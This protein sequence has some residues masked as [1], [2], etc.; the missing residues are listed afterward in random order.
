MLVWLL[1][2]CVN[3]CG[4]GTP[5][6]EVSFGSSE[7]VSLSTDFYANKGRADLEPEKAFVVRDICPTITKATLDPDRDSSFAK[8]R[9]EGR[10]LDRV[11]TLGAVIEDG[12][13]ADSILHPEGDA[14]FTAAVGCHNCRL[15]LGFEYEGT[16]VACIGPGHSLEIERGLLV[17]TQGAA[18][19]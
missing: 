8:L 9:V 16:W 10:G 7:V 11:A 6:S 2:S 5:P 13:T 19:P 12:S 4:G 18:T 3:S 14:A 1:M 17:Q 15:Q